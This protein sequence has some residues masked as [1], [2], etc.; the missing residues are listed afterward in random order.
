ML[1]VDQLQVRADPSKVQALFTGLSFVIKPGEA[2]GLKGP[3]GCGKTTLLRSIAGLIGPASGAVTLENRTP[4]EI[5]W[6][7]FRRR[8]SLVPQ[9]PVVWDGSVWSNLQR[10]NAFRSASHAIDPDHADGTLELVGLVDK[11]GEQATV[12]SEGERQ[13][14]CLVRSLLAR[15]DFVLLDEPTSALDGDAVR[16]IEDLLIRE[17]AERGLGILVATHAGWFA[18]RFCTR[19]I[20]LS[21]YIPGRQVVADA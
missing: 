13:R 4:A 2:V 15:P 1:C 7:S 10:P 12:L 20:D 18:D 9:R 11:L 21:D 8:V 6:P 5:G 14:I 17:T 19:V 3:S 16:R